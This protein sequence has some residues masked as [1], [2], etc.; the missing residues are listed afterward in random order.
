MHMN[1]PTTLTMCPSCER[2]AVSSASSSSSAAVP[3]PPNRNPLGPT[4]QRPVPINPWAAM[5]IQHRPFDGP[6]PAPT[7]RP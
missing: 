5:S 2:V 7:S 6:A 4:I 1:P 3:A